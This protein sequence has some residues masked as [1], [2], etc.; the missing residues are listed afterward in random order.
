MS[1]EAKKYNEGMKDTRRIFYLTGCYLSKMMSEE[2][3]DE[4]DELICANEKNMK[5]FEILSDEK[6]VINFVSGLSRMALQNDSLL[7]VD[8]F[9]WCTC[10]MRFPKAQRTGRQ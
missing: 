1:Q 3:R 9:S 10:C 2:E 6:C 5:L 8:K 7:D 4:L